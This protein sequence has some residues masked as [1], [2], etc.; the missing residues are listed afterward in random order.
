MLAFTS[1]SASDRTEAQLGALR[2]RGLGRWEKRSGHWFTP[3]KKKW[4]LDATPVAME[5]VKVGAGE[6]P[7]VKMKLQTFIGKSLQQKGDVHVWISTAHLARP[8]VQIQADIKILYLK[9]TY[10]ISEIGEAGLEELLQETLASA[11]KIKAI[12]PRDL[13]DVTIDTTVQ[14]KNALPIDA[15]LLERARKTVVKVAEDAR[16]ELRQNYNRESPM[17]VAKYARYSH[18]KPFNRARLVRE[19]LD[20]RMTAEGFRPQSQLGEHA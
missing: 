8:I 20:S 11:L 6:F 2:S 1:A 9:H 10:N 5:T 16:V 19:R 17:L 15:K 12:K 7:S 3:P 14:K 18:A 13:D 4:W